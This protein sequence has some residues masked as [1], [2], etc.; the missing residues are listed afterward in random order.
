M[1]TFASI[2][3]FKLESTEQWVASCSTCPISTGVYVSVNWGL[4]VMWAVKHLEKHQEE[5]ACIEV[6]QEIP[7]YE[8]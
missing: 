4:S 3:I 2:G 7:R 8:P 5:T 6:R 1:S